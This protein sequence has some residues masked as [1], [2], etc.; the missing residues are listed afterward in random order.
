[1]GSW[2]SGPGAATSGEGVDQPYPG[3]RLGRP[4]EGSGAVAG[5]GRRLAGI[6]VDWAVSLLVAHAFLDSWRS[7]GPL[8]VLLAMHVLLV[9]T[10]GSSLGHRLLGLRVERVAGGLP[11]PLRAALRAVLL[12]LLVP[13]LIGDRDRRGLHDKASG[14]VV[15][16]I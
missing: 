13:A 11:G 6:C 14:T 4:E 16:R 3:A 8:A 7:F 2:L 1:V 9:G 12:C 15:T 5:W 10:A